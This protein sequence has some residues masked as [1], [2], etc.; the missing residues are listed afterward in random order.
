MVRLLFIFLLI[1]SPVFAKT[2]PELNS[3]TSP[4]T[5]DLTYTVDVSDTTDGSSGTGKKATIAQV[6]KAANMTVNG[7]NVGINNTSPT[8]TLDVTG[9]VKATAFSGDGSGLTG[10]SGAVSDAAYSASWDGDTTTPASKNSIYD[11]IETIATGSGGWTDGGTN[12]YVSTS[13]DKVGIGSTTP[14]A[15][16]DVIGAGYFDDTVTVGGSS[17][18]QFTTNGETISNTN[19]GYNDFSGGITTGGNI[20]V[21]VSVPT[22]AM[23]V[24][25][26]A[27]IT[28]LV[29]CDTIDTDSSGNLSCG[30]DASG[31]GS[32]GWTDG[33]T[34][35]YNTDTSDNVGIGTT[36]PTSKLTV[37]GAITTTG[38]TAGSVVLSEASANGSNTVTVSAPSSLTGDRTCTVE[39]DATPFDSCITAPVASGWTDGGTDIYT[40]T[41]SDNVGIGTTTPTATLL[42]QNVSTSNSFRVND[43]LNDVSPFV[44][45]NAG[46]VG[47]GTFLPV[48]ALLYMKQSAD[49]STSGFA[50]LNT[51]LTGSVRFW[52]D[53]GN[54]GRLDGATTGANPVLINAAGAGNV[55]IGTTVAS[56][57]LH[58]VENTA[59][60]IKVQNTDAGGGY[61]NIG[62]MDNGSSSG[63]SRLVFV[64]DSATA[65]SSALTLMNSG[66]VG[67][68]TFSAGAILSIPSLKSSSGT[69]YLCIDTSGNVSSSA[70]AC[71]GT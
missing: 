61:W 40:S 8:T 25:G 42:V 20:G 36:T 48:S 63:G 46:N 16:F 55:G 53:V 58:I 27:R 65:T 34:N 29:S 5:S 4:S 69:R 6:F 57:R 64:P 26:D 2:I 49:T 21:G 43:S 62:Q 10:V 71:S 3:N 28:G 38:T 51:N 66:N 30:T 59:Y 32:G 24:V 19:D 17:Q 11:K 9:T 37:A 44:I 52:S 68:G 54:N 14:R 39:D 67:I 22:K 13:T 12:V 1:C 31:G 15:K 70:S 35:V 56:G 41:T 50:V 45:D 33:G 23:H 7:T 18:I 60:Q 47:I